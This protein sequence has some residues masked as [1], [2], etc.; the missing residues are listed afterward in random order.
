MLSLANVSS[1]AKAAEYYEQTD[2][3]YVGDRSP[4]DWKGQAAKELGL[5]GPVKPDDFLAL[6]RGRLPN[7]V[8]LETG[9]E[10]KERRGGTDMTWSAPKSLSM[11]SLIA[12]DRRLVDAHETAVSRA[13]VEAES[14]AAC[15]MTAAGVTVA[16][17]TSLK[18][19]SLLVSLLKRL[20]LR[21][22]TIWMCVANSSLAP[23]FSNYDREG[24]CSSSL[25]QLSAASPFA[26]A[27]RGPY[28]KEII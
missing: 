21:M 15:R 3:Y 9:N 25:N 8:R 22:R 1:G 26:F 18:L 16:V 6:L 12:G 4:S 11:Q 13:L 17:G 28:K 20:M 27:E 5:S 24:G 10:V 14:L 7:G 2:D 23:N 19:A